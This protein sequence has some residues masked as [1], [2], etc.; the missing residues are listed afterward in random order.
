MTL[1][2]KK[3]FPQLPS[4]VSNFGNHKINLHVK[5]RKIIRIAEN[6]GLV[7]KS[8]PAE[9]GALLLPQP[10]PHLSGLRSLRMRHKKNTTTT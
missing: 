4:K 3:E 9:E 8:M 7:K 5:V 1:I 2:K 6:F 10:K